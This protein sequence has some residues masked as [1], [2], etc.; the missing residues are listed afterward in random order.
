MT[1]LTIA[2]EK[3]DID[4]DLFTTDAPKA[5]QNFVDLA[6]KGFYDDVVFHRVIPGFVAQ[7]GDGEHGKN[8]AS[9]P[10]A[11]GQ[12]DR[13]TSS[14]TRRSRATTSAARSR[15]RTPGRTPTAASSS[16]AIRT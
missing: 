12:A 10:A 4:V 15:W 16:S 11:S 13:A 2:T 6:R 8:R 7:A 5:S 1:S 14:R 9:M 3:G